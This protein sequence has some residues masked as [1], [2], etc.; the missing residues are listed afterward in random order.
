MSVTL[1]DQGLILD[2]QSLPLV[3]GSVHYWR[4]SA[5]DWPL[6]LDRVVALGFKIICVYLPWSVHEA[7]VGTFDFG[8]MDPA[9]NVGRFLDMAAER[10]LYVLARPGPHINAEL[11]YFGY[12]ARLFADPIYLARNAR[13][14]TAILPVP[15]RSFP[16]ISYASEAFWKELTGWFNAAATIVRPRL[17]PDGPIVAVQL[18]NEMSYF[19]RTSAYDIDYHP[20]ARRK[21]LDFVTEKYGTEY[22]VSDAYHASKLPSE[23]PLPDDFTAAEPPDLPFY[24]DWMEFKEHHLVDCLARL[25]RLWEERGV[26]DTVFFH[27]YP[28]CEARSPFNLPAA[29]RVVDFCGVD[30]YMHKH[31][32]HDLKRKLL[33]LSGQ[34]RFPVSPE[35]ASGCY[36][37]WPPVDLEDQVFTSKV[38]WMFGLKGINFYMLVERD[39]WY[40]SPITRTGA[41]RREYWDFFEAHLQLLERLRPWELQRTANVCLLSVRDY[42]RLEGAAT[43]ASPLPPL[44]LGAA[45]PPEDL[46]YEHTIG[47]ER[48]VQYLQ[49]KAMR[50]WEY[51]LTAKSIPYVIGSSDMSLDELSAFDVVI[52]PTFEF[53]CGV[54][55]KNLMHYLNKGGHLVCGPDIPGLDELMDEYALLMS[56]ATRPTEKLECDADIDVLLCE[57]GRGEMILVTDVPLPKEKIMPVAETVFDRFDLKSSYAV[58]PP[59]ETSLHEAPG[60]QVLYIANPSAEPCRCRV[61]LP[62][63]GR[64]FVDLETGHRYLSDSV[65][66]IDL[67][68]YTVRI[69]EVRR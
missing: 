55:Q 57:A 19:F 64:S 13:G 11:T 56:Y 69:L 63:A 62:E 37:W 5:K 44:G 34:S 2:G 1:G 29:E 46:C 31:E 15:P 58:T 4:H 16:V 22:K 67:A 65:L 59:C 52:C 54:T 18:D 14:G 28:V 12:P 17:Y 10:G 41:V 33:F 20:D 66:E 60:R 25:R 35:F 40:G 45:V 51:A 39:R 26:T 36:L 8:E 43:A 3:S 30:F 24:L 50:N 7:G 32:Y 47:F 61:Q 27:N 48:P 21:W 49:A 68:P 53:L 9:K 23:M 6:L 38:A 42:E